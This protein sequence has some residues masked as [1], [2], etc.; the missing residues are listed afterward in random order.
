MVL[1]FILCAIVALVILFICMMIFSTIRIQF[2][3]FTMSNIKDNKNIL[4]RKYKIIVS[5][6][7]FNRIKWLLIKLNDKKIKN[8]YSKMNLEKMDFKTLQNDFKIKNLVY[9][10]KLNPKISYLN[11]EF[12]IGTEDIIAT[13]F[14]VAII[15]SIIGILLPHV[16]KKYKENKCYYKIVPLYINKNVYEIKFDCIIEIKNVHIINIIYV[17]IKKRRDRKYEQ[18]A[19]NRR[20]YGYSYE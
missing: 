10:K 7:L 16:V 14:V 20:S 9:L 2:N 11:L 17:F 8:M 3:N 15:S 5:L 18:R 12:K 6:H 1:V 19:S 4:Q 13:S